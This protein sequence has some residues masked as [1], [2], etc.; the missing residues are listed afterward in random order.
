LGARYG[1]FT[2][3]GDGLT[4]PA[5]PQL[6]SWLA[7]VMGLGARTVILEVTSHALRLGRVKGV[8]FAGGLLAAILPGEH[9]DFHHTYEDYVSAKRL[10]LNYL[11]PDAVLAY[12]ADNRASRQLADEAAVATKLGF[13]LGT[14]GGPV[15]QIDQA[16]LDQHGI[17]F[18]VGGRQ[19]RSSLLG[20]PN[21]RNVALALTYAVA[22]GMTIDEV[23]PVLASLEPL[24]RRMERLHLAGRTVLD[25]TSGHPDSL[26]ALF[27]VADLLERKR[28]WIA[29]AIRGSRGVEVNRANAFTLADLASL[30]EAAGLIVTASEDVTSTADLVK[31]EEIDAVRAALQLRGRP[32]EFHATLQESMKA[33]AAK[34]GAG[35]L[36]VLAGAQGM[37]EGRR[38]LEQ[39]LRSG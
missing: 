23:E 18:R 22:S 8:P 32:Y 25:D 36:I 34:S 2:D 28:S 35:D 14:A 9:T 21:I 5:P 31:A 16:S 13:A 10:F 37:N 38:L 4:T 12:D 7:T 17:V 29:W 27:E 1:R 30:Q 15:M 20:R 19:I 26:M 39:A 11:R 6:H 33:V 3:P 24:P